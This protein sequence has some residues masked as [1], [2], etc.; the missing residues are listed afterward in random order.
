MLK[1]RNKEACCAVKKENLFRKINDNYAKQLSHCGDR[2]VT[3]FVGAN[4]WT[5]T[6]CS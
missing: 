6:E 3:T 4:S 2:L 1:D 5:N